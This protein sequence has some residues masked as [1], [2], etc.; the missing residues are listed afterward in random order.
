MHS[1]LIGRYLQY[2]PNYLETFNVLKELI[3]RFRRFRRFRLPPFQCW[4][5]TV[6]AIFWTKSNVVWGERVERD[7][8]S[9]RKIQKV[10]SNL[11]QVVAQYISR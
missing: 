11:A 3:E 7:V 1:T 8:G 6:T 10:S 9:L 5:V 4:S 2:G